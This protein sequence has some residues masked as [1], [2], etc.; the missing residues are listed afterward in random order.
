MQNQHQA[1]LIQRGRGA[2]RTVAQ[3]FKTRTESGQVRILFECARL[4]I[5]DDL[6]SANMVDQFLF[7]LVERRDSF[8]AK[9]IRVSVGWQRSEEELTLWCR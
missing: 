2:R 7:E 9:G 6:D 4:I 8:A 5:E 3:L 1:L